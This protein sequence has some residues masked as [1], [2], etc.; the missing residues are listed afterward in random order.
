[1]I[2]QLL[3]V[4]PEGNRKY[5][6]RYRRALNVIY[7]RMAWLKF[8]FVSEPLAVSPGVELLKS[9]ILNANMEELDSY[10]N[11]I[12][13]FTYAIQFYK[14]SRL[15]QF[16]P[17]Y[18]GKF[19]KGYF[20]NGLASNYAGTTEVLLDVDTRHPFDTFP[21]DKDFVDWHELRG[22]RLVYHDS[23]EIPERIIRGL[24]TFNK[25]AP[26]VAV[27]TID[28]PVL[29]FKYYKYWKSCQKEGNT[30]DVMWFLN[31]Y[32]YS[33][34]FSDFM[35]TWALNLF[36]YAFTARVEGKTPQEACKNLTVPTRVATDN[37]LREV[38]GGLYEYVDLY[39]QNSLR[40]QDLIDTAWFPNGTTIRERI[41]YLYEAARFP[42][43]RNYKWC[44]A[45][46]WLP[47]VD[48]ITSSLKVFPSSPVSNQIAARARSLWRSNYKFA[49]MT[50]IARGTNVKMLVDEIG[51]TV[52]E[53]TKERAH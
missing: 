32:E 12:D 48:I 25:D 8:L 4:I 5:P 26:S 45:L 38:I 33:L 34:F 1:M 39:R 53:L 9:L 2:R 20:T 43:Q 42:G 21:L 49:N 24:I 6:V 50:N 28:V 52:E 7:S 30:P 16:D 11:D 19:T 47:Y 29:V 3:D 44:E 31:N 10:P 23:L 17:V 14:N 36:P 13:R 40:P 46:F 27:M 35:D 37:V 41:N 18:S 15:M 51:R 22:L